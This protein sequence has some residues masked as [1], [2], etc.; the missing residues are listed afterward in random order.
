MYLSTKESQKAYTLKKAVYVHGP[1]WNL[2]Q[3][4]VKTT[5]Q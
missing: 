3:P 5:K 2:I 1:A 4:C